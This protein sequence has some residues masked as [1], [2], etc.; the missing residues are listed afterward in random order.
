MNRIALATIRYCLPEPAVP[1]R[2]QSVQ[3]FHAEGYVGQDFRKEADGF[4][5][6]SCSKLSVLLLPANKMVFKLGE[7]FFYGIMRG[8]AVPKSPKRRHHTF[9]GRLVPLN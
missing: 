5:M 4:L 9:L 2:F 1:S 6:F 3:H 7:T 8:K